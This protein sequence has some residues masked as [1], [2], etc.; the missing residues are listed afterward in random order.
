MYPS[1]APGNATIERDLLE[2]AENAIM[3]QDQASNISLWIR[4]PGLIGGLA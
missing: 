4:R 2:H 3:S 1:A